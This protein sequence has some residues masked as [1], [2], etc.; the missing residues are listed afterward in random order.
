MGGEHLILGKG[1][2]HPGTSAEAH[3]GDGLVEAAQLTQILQVLVHLLVADDR[4]G[5]VTDSLQIL[6]LIKN[7]TGIGIQINGQAV[8]SLLGGD[9]DIILGHILLPE[10]VHIRETQGCKGTEAEEVA[11]PGKGTGL[12]DLFLILIAIHIEQLDL[13]AVLGN[14]EIVKGIQFILVQED[15]G[16]PSTTIDPLKFSGFFRFLAFVAYLY[17]KECNFFQPFGRRFRLMDETAPEA[18]M[19]NL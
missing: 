11:G 7:G 2:F 14:W 4:Q 6:I 1:L 8:V 10:V 15:D 5:I 12:L 16:L 19:L 18:E 9:I 13:L 3:T 17:E